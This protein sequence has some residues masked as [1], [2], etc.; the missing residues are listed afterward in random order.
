[1]TQVESPAP[2]SSYR[3][4]NEAWLAAAYRAY[5]GCERDVY[6][7]VAD[8]IDEQVRLQLTEGAD[9]IQVQNGLEYDPAPHELVDDFTESIHTYELSVPAE[10]FGFEQMVLSASGVTYDTAQITDVH[11]DPGTVTPAF[12]STVWVRCELGFRA[13][14]A[15]V[16]QTDVQCR[17]YAP[18]A[19][20][21]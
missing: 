2:R 21:G 15:Q 11:E 6:A 17:I 20:S 4:D 1:M 14:I 8:F 9:D 10:A 16:V 13:N 7:L 5:Q 19:T 12:E 3:R 18:Q